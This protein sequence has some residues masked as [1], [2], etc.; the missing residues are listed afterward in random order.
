MRTS[1]LVATACVAITCIGCTA[2]RHDKAFYLQHDAER[3]AELAKCGT[4][5][6]DAE[7]AAAVDAQ[8]TTDQGNSKALH[9]LDKKL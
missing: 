6:T 5:T 9:A 8:I 3:K 7:C 2:P 1:V 4:N